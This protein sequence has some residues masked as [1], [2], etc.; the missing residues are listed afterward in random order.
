MEGHSQFI[1]KTYLNEITAVIIFFYEYEEFKYYILIS[2]FSTRRGEEFSEWTSKLWLQ[3]TLQQTQNAYANETISTCAHCVPLCSVVHHPVGAVWHSWSFRV[4]LTLW[5]P[6]QDG[7]SIYGPERGQ[8]ENVCVQR[9][10]ET[11]AMTGWWMR[12]GQ[13]GGRSA[14]KELRK[15]VRTNVQSLTLFTEFLWRES[16]WRFPQFY[17]FI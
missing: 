5:L 16:G 9:V 7:P 4:Y 13:D 15:R 17:L 10:G 1:T 3:L 12:F 14:V 6:C 11:A 8:A 2:T